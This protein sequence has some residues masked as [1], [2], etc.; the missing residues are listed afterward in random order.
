[1]VCYSE[2]TDPMLSE[3]L[4]HTRFLLIGEATIADQAIVV[5]VADLATIR[6]VGQSEFVLVEVGLEQELVQATIASIQEPSAEVGLVDLQLQGEVAA[7]DRDELV[8]SKEL[9]WRELLATVQAT[10]QASVQV[11]PFLVAAE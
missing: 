6:V 1:M 11:E 8:E 2:D 10:V 7:A 3:G 5:P 4:H 9:D